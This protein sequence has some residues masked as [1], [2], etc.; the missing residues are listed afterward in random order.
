MAM[1]TAIFCALTLPMMLANVAF[2]GL[3][4]KSKV[5]EHKAEEGAETVAGRFEFTN[6]GKAPVTIRNIDTSCRCLEAKADK[7]VYQPGESGV[8]EAKFEIRGLTGQI[9]KGLTLS[10]DD[11]ATPF[12]RLAVKIEVPLIIQIEPKM[13]NWAIGEEPKAKPI[14]FRVMREKPVHI[15]S[16]DVS[17]KNFAGVVKTI[18]EG[19]LYHI[20]LTPESTEA[21]MLGVVS[22]ETDCE[23]EAQ[24][25]QLGFFRIQTA[26]ADDEDE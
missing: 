2:G 7:K 20:E 17:R 11:P 25:R 5:S 6:D 14:V 24:A 26:D 9:E 19:K 23:I 21:T 3:N 8:V 13:I 4:F 18:E 16:I 10:T 15:K 12:I 1:R 22:I